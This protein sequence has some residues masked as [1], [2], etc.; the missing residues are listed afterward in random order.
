MVR[1]RAELGYICKQMQMICMSLVLFCS[2]SI[3]MTV[4]KT[5]TLRVRPRLRTLSGQGDQSLQPIF[6]CWARIKRLIHPVWNNGH[7]SLQWLRYCDLSKSLPAKMKNGT[8]KA[9]GKTSE[10]SWSQNAW[11]RDSVYYSLMFSLLQRDCYK[12]LTST[13]VVSITPVV[14]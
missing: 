2:E 13:S 1:N 10:Q 14:C 6:G 5:T 8:Y 7:G 9:K 12:A 4:Q 11:N 3:K